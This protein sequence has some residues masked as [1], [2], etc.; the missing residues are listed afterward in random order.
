M[1]SILEMVRILLPLILTGGIA[2]FVVMRMKHK[3]EEGTL[4]KKK[5]KGAQQL[6]DSLIP[7]VMI[8]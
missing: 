3:Y 8:V 7:L 5:S 2:I 6:L 4:G 1:S